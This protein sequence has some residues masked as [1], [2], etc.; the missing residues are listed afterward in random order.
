MMML[1]SDHVDVSQPSQRSQDVRMYVFNASAP[2]RRQH[3][4]T[5]QYGCLLRHKNNFFQPMT[6]FKQP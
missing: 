1:R 6:V 3:N 5:H 2:I 4:H